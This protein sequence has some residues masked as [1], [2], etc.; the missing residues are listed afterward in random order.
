MMPTIRHALHTS[1][2]LD[3]AVGPDL[4][5]WRA[6]TPGCQD[7]IH[8]NN[9]GAA[10][11]PQSV[12]GTMQRHLAREAEIGGYEAADEAAPR[13]RD[14]Y[15]LLGAVIGAP[16]RNVA[17]VENATVAVSQALSAFDFRPGDVLVTSRCDY[18]SNQLMYV[19]LARRTGL[20]VHRADDLPEGGVD[21]ESVRQLVRNPRCRLVVLTWVP[22]NSGLIQAAEAVGAVCAEA[23]IPF[24]LD[25]CQSVGQMPID[26]TRLKCDYLAGTAR[27]FLR[28]PRGIGFLYI[29]ERAL[30]KGAYPLYVDMRGAEWTA[31]DEFILADG[32]RRFENWEFAYALVLGMGEAARYALAVGDAGFTRTRALAAELRAK[33]QALPNVRVYDRGAELCAIVTIAVAGHEPDVLK[34]Q[35]RARG[36]NV[37]VTDRDDGVLDLE[38]KG[39]TALL[40]LSPHYYNTVAELDEAVAVL[41]ELTGA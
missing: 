20:V 40:R 14:V 39:V 24:I 34:L 31:A 17:I 23:G 15:G 30:A 10:L 9:A 12:L 5:R 2:A 36:I 26:V 16:A 6:D 37:S 22:T 3:T 11:P 8:L 1:S 18:P 25:A 32:A 38:T 4:D 13:V 27:K 35:L 33:L 41:D 29:S 7:R 21:P 19:S 28:G